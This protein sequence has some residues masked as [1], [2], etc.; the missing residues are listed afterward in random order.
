MK[1]ITVVLIFSMISTLT[2]GQIS[3]EEIK[4]QK[5]VYLYGLGEGINQRKAD[6]AALDDLISQIQVRV[7]SEYSSQLEETIEGDNITVEEYT[8]AMIKTYS[9]SDLTQAERLIISEDPYQ[10]VRYIKREKIAEIF[11][12]RKNKV[13]DYVESADKA[14]AEGKIAD[15]IKYNY[16]ALVMLK[17]LP[18]SRSVTVTDDN[19]DEDILSVELPRKINDIFDN[20]RIRTLSK[21]VKNKNLGM[22]VEATY[23]GVPVTNLDFTYWD[24]VGKSPIQSLKDGIG[25]IYLYNQTTAPDEIQ[26]QIEYV[27]ADQWGI[28][29]DLL[30]VMEESRRIKFK[31]SG[32]NL[33][34]TEKPSAAVGTN[35]SRNRNSSYITAAEVTSK[36]NAKKVSAAKINV[37]DYKEPMSKIVSAISSK[38]YKAAASEFT[39]EGLKMYNDLLTYGKAEI[40]SSNTEPVAIKI[41][42]QI[43]V[44]SIP[45]KFSFPRN[46]RSFTEDVNFIFNEDQKVE[47]IS[48]ALSQIAI[49]DIMKKSRWPETDK[50]QIIHFME[51][52]KT[53]YCLKRL[54][55]LTSIFD[56]DALIIVGHVV[57]QN[58]DAA[59]GLYN[60]EKVEYNK[61]TKQE[62]MDKLKVLFRTK[63]YVNIQFED[64]EVLAGKYPHTYGIQIKQNYYSSNYGDKGYLFL[65][66]DLQDPDKPTIYVRT[67]QPNK[68]ANGQIFGIQ[69]F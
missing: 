55:Y 40:I 44:R 68:D 31:K 63:E 8:E 30:V 32:Y 61:Y 49:N 19:G 27:Q 51:N 56:D 60:N 65:L 54:D 34:T 33:K 6:K 22:E 59:T 26:L 64:N 58:K 17:S 38:N 43:V 53:A 52:Y 67:W 36:K 35:S 41:N 14:E 66:I 50:Y 13:F 20:I 24:G 23:K 16:W 69:D 47:A 3:F 10:V 1:K 18:D 5:D 45:M 57:K 46:N 37:E 21:E 48:F 4:M 62:Y 39:P 28:D 25:K 11:E 2:W 9:S 7:V 42:N 15:A 12:A 29:K